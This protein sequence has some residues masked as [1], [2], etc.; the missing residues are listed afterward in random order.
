MPHSYE[1]LDQLEEGYSTV[2]G[3]TFMIR[4]DKD[5]GIVAAARRAVASLDPSLPLSKL[6]T[7]QEVMDASLQPRRFNTWLVGL[8]AA[9][10]LFLAVIGIY[11]VIA[12]AV[13]Q[14][15]QEI[16][17]RMAL[18]AKT[19]DVLFLREGLMLA[20]AGILIGS[21]AALPMGRYIATLLYGEQPTDVATFAM[22]SGVLAATAIAA[23]YLPARRA[24]RLE[25]MLALRHR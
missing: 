24:M 15:T 9:L 6:R 25:P 2:S 18:G 1:P 7:M 3:L 12:F 22:V 11:G 20:F 4:G 10:A 16:G 23:T 17:I 14:R 19:G 21:A 8:F 5:A 13:T